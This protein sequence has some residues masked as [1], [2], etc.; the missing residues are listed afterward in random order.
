MY[1]GIN[2]FTWESPFNTQSARLIAKAE[3]MGFDLFEVAF[4]DPENTDLDEV[5]RAFQ[6]SKVVPS[7]CG[8]FGPGRDISSDDPAIQKQGMEYIASC[9]EAARA[10][11]SKV[12]GG[13]MYACVGKAR[14][15]PDNERKKERER[16]AAALKELAQHAARYGIMLAIEPLNRFENDM[17]NTVEQ[18]MAYL[19]LVNEP[20][21]GL[22]VDLFHA[23]IE[24]DDIGAALR[25]A[26]DRLL[27]VHASE[28]HRGTPGKGQVRWNEVAAALHDIGYQGSVTI[29]SFTPNAESVRQAACIWRPLAESQDALAREGLAFLRSLFASGASATA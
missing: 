3:Q 11:G 23:H 9:I 6:N 17:I 15:L 1:L 28:N 18:A 20:N 7:V 12:V 24:E 26:G 4:E 16:S 5:R 22:H 14:A 21:V 13:P 25:L 8:A 19:D 10:W 27:I 2:S 29:E